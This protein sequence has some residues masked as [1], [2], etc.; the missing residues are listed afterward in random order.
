MTKETKSRSLDALIYELCQ[1]GEGVG[2]IHPLDRAYITNRL[3]ALFKANAYV[4]PSEPIEVRPL[5]EILED[6]TEEALSRHAVSHLV[7]AG[8]VAANSH[9]RRRIAEVAKKCGFS[10]V[11]AIRVTLPSSMYSSRDCCCFLLKYCISSR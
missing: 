3:L 8:G 7:M 11:E 1:Y 9:L 10:V 5:A 2:L 4:A 6:M